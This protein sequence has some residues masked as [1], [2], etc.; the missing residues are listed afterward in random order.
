MAM[1]KMNPEELLD[2]SAKLEQ[3]ANECITLANTISAN[4]EAGTANFEGE[5]KGKYVE[6]FAQM[7][8]ILADKMPAMISEF[9]A[10]LKRTAENWILM[11]GQR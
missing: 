3:N 7:K 5:T 4:F 6:A 1:M 9:A 8:P 2:L 11:D 10:E